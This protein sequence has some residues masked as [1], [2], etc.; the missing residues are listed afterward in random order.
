MDRPMGEYIG[1]GLYADILFVGDKLFFTNRPFKYFRSFDYTN[2]I[3]SNSELV[4]TAQFQSFC[5]Y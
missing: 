5:T 1:S 3:I 4:F 2:I